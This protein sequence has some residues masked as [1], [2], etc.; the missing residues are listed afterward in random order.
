MSFL[1]DTVKKSE[2][3][4]ERLGYLFELSS[5]AQSKIR[6]THHPKV[7]FIIFGTGRSGSTLLVDMLRSNPQIHCDNELF[8][9]KLVNPFS[10]IERRAHMFDAIAYGFKCLTYQIYEVLGYTNHQEFI[11]TLHQLGYKI[12]YLRRDNTLMQALSNMYARYRNIYHTKANKRVS[13]HTSKI[14]VDFEVLDDWMQR[15][16]E[17]KTFEQTLLRDV[18]HLNVSYEADLMVPESHRQTVQ[19]IGEFLGIDCSAAPKVSLRKASPTQLED[20]VENLSEL[21]LHFKN[22]MVPV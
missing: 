9:R 15:L 17:Q 6:K 1:L 4:N 19:K 14:N 13:G 11:D 8:H 20:Y 21:K 12:I 7:K 16:D 3:I 10:L 2:S 18:P 5:Y 22:K